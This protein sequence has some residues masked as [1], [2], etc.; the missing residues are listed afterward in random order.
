MERTEYIVADIIYSKSQ[1]IVSRKTTVCTSNHVNGFY[2]AGLHLLFD[3]KIG[4][5]IYTS[6]VCVHCAV[7]YQCSSF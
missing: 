2:K 5:I 1:T 4:K 7:T 6:K 3:A